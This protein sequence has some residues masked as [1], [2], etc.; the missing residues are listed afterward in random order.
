MEL[1]IESRLSE[2]NK[3][4]R[5][6]DRKRAQRANRRILFWGMTSYVIACGLVGWLIGTGGL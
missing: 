1:T 2:I 4:A 6:V 3:A 5:Y